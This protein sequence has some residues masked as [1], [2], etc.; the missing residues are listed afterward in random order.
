MNPTDYLHLQLRLEGKSVIGSNLLRQVEEVPGEEMPLLLI[1]QLADGKS[2]TYVNE[3][4]DPELQEGLV[5]R[6]R[7]VQF[8]Q[9]GPLLQFLTIENISFETGHYKTY[10]IPAHAAV[11]AD[12]EVTCFSREDPKVQAFGFGGFAEWVYGIEQGGKIASACVSA[13]ENDFCGE[14][15]V[16]TD[17]AYRHH[18]LAQKVVCTWAKGLISSGKVPFYSHKIKNVASAR[19]A[20]RLGL[21]PLFEEMVIARLADDRMGADSNRSRLT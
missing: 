5:K 9:I 17:P 19:L 3:A 6:V 18:G 14:A 4:L 11:F 21:Q 13:R 7:S 15:W 8:P 16:F 2:V 20:K 12:E 10:W 1:A